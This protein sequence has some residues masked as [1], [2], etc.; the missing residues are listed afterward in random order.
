MMTEEQK[1]LVE[2]N[3]NL[4]Y[5]MIHKMNE[6]VEE[7]YDLAAI[8]LCKA[9]ISY[10]SDNGS[11][12]NYACRCIRNEIL[13]D[14]RARMMPKRWMNEY[15]ISYDAPS[16]VQNEDGEESI[17][18]DQLK[19]FE[20]VENEALSR[21]MYLEVVAELGKTDSKVLKFFEMGLKQREIAEIMGVT[22]AN[23]SRV[24]RRVE[25]MLC[26]D[27]LEGLYGKAAVDKQ[28]KI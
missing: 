5:F 23:V 18:L 15:L 8:A 20:S 25:K 9:A 26:C 10:Q 19:S 2:N 1:L 12:S 13:L 24:K 17:L 6:S 22:Q 27:W 16:V 28:G 7:Y 14:H 11:F 4:I 3:H 21:I